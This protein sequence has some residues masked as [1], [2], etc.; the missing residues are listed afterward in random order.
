M[1][2]M[3]SFQMSEVG[4][5]HTRRVFNMWL[6]LAYVGGLTYSLHSIIGWTVE[7]FAKH[8]FT[9]RALKRLYVARTTE[10]N[11][12]K[13]N[14]QDGKRFQRHF[15]DLDLENNSMFEG[16]QSRGKQRDR[17]N[18]YKEDDALQSARSSQGLRNYRNEDQTPGAHDWNG[19]NHRQPQ[20]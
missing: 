19:K 4:L 5:K 15:E 2:L 10:R 9:L 3:E 1:L 20:Q 13:E 14:P 18:S 11:A 17:R 12:F 7:P 16:G 6:F 8:G